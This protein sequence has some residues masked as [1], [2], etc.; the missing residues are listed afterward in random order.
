V[1]EP[2]SKE[3]QARL[4]GYVDSGYLYVIEA[5]AKSMTAA[6]WWYD[7][8]APLSSRILKGGTICF[9]HT[10]ERL[11]GITAEHVHSECVSVMAANRRIVAQIGSHTFEPERC[12]ID[13]DKPL[14]LAVY[15]LS[16]V[17]VSINATV[18]RA[19]VWPPAVEDEL[20]FIVGGY[21]WT[22]TTSRDGE[23]DHDFLHFIAP[24]SD[25]TKTRL[26][27]VTRTSTSLPWGRRGLLLGTNRGGM[28][29]GPLFQLHERGLRALTLVGVVSEYARDDEYIIARPL[30]LVD[31]NGA[32]LR[33]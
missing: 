20:P 23:S 9:V 8:A 32:I 33:N 5:L 26:V 17:Q 27:V 19:V 13:L 21:P 12:L 11:L 24:L 10:G 18:H 3:Q 6:Y 29:G 4:R 2:L 1:T 22:L 28:S 31:A 16:E 14:D 15:G 25:R 7:P 30:S